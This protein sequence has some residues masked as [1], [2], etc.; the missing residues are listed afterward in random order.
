MIVEIRQRN[1][2][3]RTKLL[4][5]V[6]TEI[7]RRVRSRGMLL[8]QCMCETRNMSFPHVLP[9]ADCQVPNNNKI[10]AYFTERFTGEE[11][12][13]ATASTLDE[14]TLHDVSC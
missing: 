5:A 2:M 11:G 1:N 6:T 10:P 4:E 12:P 13:K 3:S 14:I 8:T 7:R 9:F